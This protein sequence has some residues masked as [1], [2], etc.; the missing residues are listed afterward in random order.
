MITI[1]ITAVIILAV[2]QNFIFADEVWY[3]M[4]CEQLKELALSPEHRN[5]TEQQ[6]MEFHKVL[7]PCIEG[8]Q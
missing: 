5:F 2:F 4:N 7:Q 1:G 8:D 6:H 3:G